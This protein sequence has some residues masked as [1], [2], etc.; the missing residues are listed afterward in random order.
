MRR[1][2]IVLVIVLFACSA[3]VSAGR[4][5]IVTVN[6]VS[7]DELLDPRQK[8]I[9]ALVGDGAIGVMNARTASGAD[10]EVGRYSMEG[11]CA[12]IGAGTRASAGVD[13][14]EAFDAGDSDQQR[15]VRETYES[16]SAHDAGNAEVLHLEI[17]SLRFD[18]ADAHYPIKIGELGTLLHQAGLRTAIVGNS[19]QAAIKHREA[20]LIVADDEGVVDF[21]DVGR[22]LSQ[23]D[24]GWPYSTRT[25]SGRLISAYREAIRR[26]DVV[27]VDTGDTSRA[28]SYSLLCTASQAEIFS[29]RAVAS[30]DSIIGALVRE[31]DLSKDRIVVI[32]PSPSPAAVAKGD[33][34][35][36]VVAAGAGIAPGLLFSHSTRTP[37]LLT[38]A[39]ISASVL[40]FFGIALPSSFV[41]RPLSVR[42]GSVPDVRQVN[43]DAIMVTLRQPAMRGISV[44]ML[45]MVVLA[46]VGAVWGRGRLRW[47]A[48]VALLPTATILGTLWLPAFL[49]A[50]L[51][52]SVAAL[53]ALTA[54]IVLV[55]GTVLRS[56]WKVFVW[57]CLG[58]ILTVLFDV[59]RGSELL[60]HSIMSYSPVEGARYYGIGNE[61]MGSAI[62][63]AMIFAGVLASA[64]LKRPRLRMVT[65]G[66]F[67]TAVTAAIGL[68]P[69]GANAGGAM[70]AAAAVAV[71]L[72]L[73]RGKGVSRKCIPL[74]IVAIPAALGLLLL[75]DSF[76]SGSSQS[77]V[78]R[79]AN[80]IASG[81]LVEMFG[82]IERKAAMNLML[83][84]FSLWSKLLIGSVAAVVALLAIGELGVLSRLRAN[85]SIF[86]G[87]VAAGV[88]AVA[89]FLFNDSGVVAGATAFIYVWT[90]VLL[91]SLA[92]K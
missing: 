30:A 46:S 41:G 59:A 1:L 89:A 4:L 61:H 18:N 29:R 43:H 90:A 2:L 11:A 34:L 84:Q 64:M 13:A 19:D 12:T 66:V 25:D 5:V 23:R 33:C 36:P 8:N 50:G 78:G 58:V 38:N 80:L 51:V 87:V 70:S 49:D 85:R 47:P 77:H 79:A 16:R 3:A 42:S 88:G 37:G 40:D 35:V 81:G 27:V 53:S 72:I 17:N 6:G 10:E 83:L 56:P 74:A 32:S 21:G 60:R 7:L 82:I 73:W 54:S 52:C 55:G 69:L 9:N 65:L 91:A 14:R 67:L 31:L 86:Y 44:F 62:G 22:R 68:P 28:A 75:F 20:A 45:V 63:A 57:V 39:D 76:T 48:W 26:A 24:D 92:T 71:G 15:P